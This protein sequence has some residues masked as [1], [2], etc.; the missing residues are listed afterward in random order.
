MLLP[1]GIDTVS[2]DDG[3]HEVEGV[4]W[5]GRRHFGEL[6]CWDTL[7]HDSV[8]VDW[9]GGFNNVM[10]DEWL[11]GYD[12]DLAVGAGWLEDYDGTDDASAEGK[13]LIAALEPSLDGEVV[14]KEC[15]VGDE[16]VMS[17]GEAAADGVWGA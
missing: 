5:G 17:D 16:D 1:G 12:D 3:S 13:V 4:Q 8:P 6:S 10:E 2:G 9:L 11:D 14:T 7:L 15:D